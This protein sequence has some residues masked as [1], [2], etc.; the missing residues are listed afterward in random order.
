MSFC[1]D[2]EV[3]HSGV[4]VA[5]LQLNEQVSLFQH[6]NINA[7]AKNAAFLSIFHH[8]QDGLKALED[9]NA[10][11]QD[12]LTGYEVFEQH[13]PCECFWERPDLLV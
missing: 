7:A 4:V 2:A 9:E 6:C 1:Q 12:G 13:V 3:T 10:E 5:W 11:L 8:T